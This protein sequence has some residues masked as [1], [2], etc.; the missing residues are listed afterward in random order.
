MFT[1]FGGGYSYRKLSWR[2]KKP[3]DMIKESLRSHDE[4]RRN[5]VKTKKWQVKA[6]VEF[7]FCGDLQHLLGDID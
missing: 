2:I 7:E 4:E 3:V 6:E 5:R 1:H